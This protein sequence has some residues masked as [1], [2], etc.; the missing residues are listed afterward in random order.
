MST[1]QTIKC[2]IKDKTGIPHFGTWIHIKK[3]LGSCVYMFDTR[4]YPFIEKTYFDKWQA[5]LGRFNKLLK[6]ISENNMKQ[7]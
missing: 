6:E 4:T 1:W 5:R 7:N 2:S 3:S